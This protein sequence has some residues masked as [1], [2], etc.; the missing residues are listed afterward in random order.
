M[1]KKEGGEDGW[2]TERV[3]GNMKF[4]AEEIEKQEQ[5][6][7]IDVDESPKE[8]QRGSHFLLLSKNVHPGRQR[9]SGILPEYPHR[10]RQGYCYTWLW[11]ARL[12]LLLLSELSF[13]G[14]P[15]HRL[16]VVI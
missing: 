3:A 7:L 2:N 9:S 4:V 10:P 5:K 8:G 12:P 16:F 15:T 6:A 14:K 1:E 13:L 11:S